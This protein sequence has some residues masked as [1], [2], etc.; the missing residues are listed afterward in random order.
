MPILLCLFVFIVHTYI[1][2]LEHWPMPSFFGVACL[3]SCE[4]VKKN[5]K[6]EK[7]EIKRETEKEKEMNWYI[8]WPWK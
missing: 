5:G 4:W 8:G 3:V 6:M 1:R 7:K 2:Y